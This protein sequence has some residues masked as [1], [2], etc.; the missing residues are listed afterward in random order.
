MWCDNKNKQMHRAIKRTMKNEE[1][2]G[3]KDDKIK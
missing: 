3:E 2:S 1:N